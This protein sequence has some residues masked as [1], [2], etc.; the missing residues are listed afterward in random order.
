M[1]GVQTCA[2]PISSSTDYSDS[3][4]G[5]SVTESLVVLALIVAV[6]FAV[7]CFS[8]DAER[9]HT[10]KELEEA[11]EHG[12]PPVLHTLDASFKKKS[13]ADRGGVAFVAAGFSSP[14]VSPSPVE[15]GL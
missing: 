6:S 5:L 15:A 14:K 13:L 9:E 1:T 12:R 2:L 3:D 4:S 8:L 11:A 10:Y 7:H